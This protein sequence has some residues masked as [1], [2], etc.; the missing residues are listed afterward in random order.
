M[1]YLANY[2][3]PAATSKLLNYPKIVPEEDKQMKNDDD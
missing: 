3:L 1:G 2:Y